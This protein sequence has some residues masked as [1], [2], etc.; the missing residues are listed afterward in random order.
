MC[1]S[2]LNFRY[3]ACT[4]REILLDKEGIKR[5]VVSAREKRVKM[6]IFDVMTT[7]LRDENQSWILE[8]NLV[9]LICLF[10]T[11][12]KTVWPNHPREVA[13]QSWK[14]ATV[15]NML[16]LWWSDKTKFLNLVLMLS[17]LRYLSVL[18]QCKISYIIFE[19]MSVKSL[20]KNQNFLNR[21]FFKA[22]LG[23]CRFFSLALI[24]T[25]FNPFDAA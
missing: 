23:A 13:C 6:H 3:R 17:S 16:P 12:F 22:S 10:W 1:S 11:N 21:N 24:A 14:M 15:W 9:A 2:D 18:N 19:Y 4:G 7:A 25:A 8:N 5:N 20:I